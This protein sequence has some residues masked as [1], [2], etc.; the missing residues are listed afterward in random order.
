MDL[1]TLNLRWLWFVESFIWWSRHFMKPH[2]PLF[3][4]LRLRPNGRHFLDNILKWIFLNENVLISIII[5]L[6]FVPK[7]LIDNKPTLVH[8]HLKGDKPLSEP[9]MVKFTKLVLS[10]LWRPFSGH[11]PVSTLNML[12]RNMIQEQ[13]ILCPLSFFLVDFFKCTVQS[14]IFLFVVYFCDGVSSIALDLR[15]LGN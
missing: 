11:H 13:I 6:K 5:S 10:Q 1:V 3:N 8:W 14:S 2:N 4:T 7:V 9:M 12:I 15:T